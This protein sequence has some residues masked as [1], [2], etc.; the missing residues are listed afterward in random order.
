MISAV[1]RDGSPPRRGDGPRVHEARQATPVSEGV[2]L[3]RPGT[4]RRG[5]LPAGENEFRVSGRDVERVVALNDVTSTEAM[6]YIGHRLE[7]LGVNK[8]LPAPAPPTA[9]SCGSATSAS[10]TGTPDMRLVV[11]VGTSSVTD[12]RGSVDHGAI[13]KLAD[14]IAE[15]RDGGH[16]VIVVLRRRRCRRRRPRAHLPA[17]GHGDAAG[18]VSGRPATPHAQL[19]HRPRRP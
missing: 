4:D 2:V 11:K 1:T 12:D 13:R 7:R 15:L 9:T 18:A 6:S 16:E 14:E 8:L 3:L 5:G 10:N 17:D 19:G